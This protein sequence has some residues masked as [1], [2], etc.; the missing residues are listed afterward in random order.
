MRRQLIAVAAGLVIVVAAVTT[1]V[2]L[3]AGRST[4]GAPAPAGPATLSSLWD[5]PLTR[6]DTD[7][8]AEVAACGP[9]SAQKIQQTAHN[10]IVDATKRGASAVVTRAQDVEKAAGSWL[11]TCGAVYSMSPDYNRCDTALRVIQQGPR[12]I[13][14][15]IH[16][17]DQHA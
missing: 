13:L 11:D 16:T 5:A 15:E 6:M 1:W 9:G 8:C 10:V 3:G 7:Q 4:A 17:F 12:L 14:D 2:L